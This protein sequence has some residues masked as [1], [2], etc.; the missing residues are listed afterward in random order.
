MKPG[1]RLKAGLQPKAVRQKPAEPMAPASQIKPN[2]SSAQ[3]RT[4]LEETAQ[5]LL[6]IARCLHLADR[7]GVVISWLA[8]ASTNQA[9]W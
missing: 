9:V 8:A 4:T 6:V 5:Y 1:F 7:P 2:F 3:T